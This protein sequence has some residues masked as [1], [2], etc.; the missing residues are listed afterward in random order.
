M[1]NEVVKSAAPCE[2]HFRQTVPESH[3]LLHLAPIN[4]I[5]DMVKAGDKFPADSKLSR[6][7]DLTLDNQGYNHYLD[8]L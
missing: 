2:G 6:S 1:V 4:N 3:L 8:R 5:S 7:I